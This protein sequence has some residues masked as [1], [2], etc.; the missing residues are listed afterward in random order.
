MAKH[1]HATVVEVRTTR[2][3]DGEFLAPCAWL[4]TDST[5][6]R[7]G[8]DSEVEARELAAQ[9]NNPTHTKRERGRV[10]HP[11]KEGLLP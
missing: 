4:A 7:F 10:S 2:A 11:H 6:R 8:G 3:E 5:G 9:Y 1:R